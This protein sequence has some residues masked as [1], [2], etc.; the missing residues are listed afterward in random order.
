MVPTNWAHFTGQPLKS[1]R[2]GP[3]CEAPSGLQTIIHHLQPQGG[4]RGHKTLLTGALRETGFP[5][6]LRRGSL[7]KGKSRMEGVPEGRRPKPERNQRGLGD[8]KA[9][10]SA[11]G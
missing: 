11:G 4:Q 3:C 9:G 2:S 1:C 10:F 6:G 7:N 8:G 5:E